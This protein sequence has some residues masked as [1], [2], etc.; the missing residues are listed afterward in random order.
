MT[1][2]PV[3]MLIFLLVI[4]V[5]AA[6]LVSADWSSVFKSSGAPTASIPAGPG[7]TSDSPAALGSLTSSPTATGTSTA[8]TGELV[9]SIP[10]RAP[11][12]AAFQDLAEVLRFDITPG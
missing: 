7:A 1:N 11:D 8:E 4:G 5:P 12:T 2:K 3:F 10:R 6:L 9:P